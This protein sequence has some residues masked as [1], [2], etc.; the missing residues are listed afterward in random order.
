MSTARE[1]ATYI[2]EEFL[3]GTKVE[4]LDPAYELIETGV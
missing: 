2:V 3:P 1:I 4:D